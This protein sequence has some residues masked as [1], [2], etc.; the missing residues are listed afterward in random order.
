M[1]VADREGGSDWE[2]LEAEGPV[3]RL[4]QWSQQR[5]MRPEQEQ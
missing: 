1:R 2:R 5:M 3:E 4:L